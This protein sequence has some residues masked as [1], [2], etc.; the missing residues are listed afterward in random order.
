MPEPLFACV[1]AVDP[2]RPLYLLGPGGRTLDQA[3]ARELAAGDGFSLLCGRYEGVDARVVD[4]LVDG[5]LSI[6]DYVLSGGEV[7]AMVVLGPWADHGPRGRGQRHLGGRVLQRRPARVP[8][9][10]PACRVRG[11]GGA[12]GAAPGDHAKVARW[13]C[14]PGPRPHPAGSARPDRAPR[15]AL[16]PTRRSSPSSQWPPHQLAG[17]GAGSATADVDLDHAVV[18]QRGP[19]PVATTPIDGETR[20]RGR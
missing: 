19:L 14:A 16:L 10:H 12:G 3:M 8:A 2:P 1:E 5:E 17:D 9:L 18:V 13:H 6:G 7:A 20:A 4:H 11:V 15:R